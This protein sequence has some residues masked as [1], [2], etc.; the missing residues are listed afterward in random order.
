MTISIPDGWYYDPTTDTYWPAGHPGPSTDHV[1]R[2]HFA[3]EDG[4]VFS[5]A[6][7]VLQIR[8]FPIFCPFIP[9]AVSG[10]SPS[11]F[12]FVRP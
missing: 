8:R 9:L 1:S 5:I 4:K 11:Q 12:Y 2:T 6:Y 3:D 7:S 10:I